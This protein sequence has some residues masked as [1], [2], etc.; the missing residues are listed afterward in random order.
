VKKYDTSSCENAGGK[1]LAQYQLKNQRKEQ[2][3]KANF[4]I[5]QDGDLSMVAPLT[6]HAI[7]RAKERGISLEEATKQYGVLTSKGIGDVTATAF[8]R[9]VFYEKKNDTVVDPLVSTTDCSEE[10]GDKA[11]ELGTG[12]VVVGPSHWVRN[13]D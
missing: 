8:R 13:Y 5:T 12:A 3:G 10:D 2:R 11:Q 7:R 1:F 9:N 4:R 6:K